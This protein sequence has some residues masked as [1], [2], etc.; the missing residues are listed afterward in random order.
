MTAQWN[1]V[2]AGYKAG[3]PNINVE[4]K[5]FE[6]YDSVLKTGLS[7]TKGPD[8]VM[9]HPYNA[10]EP[11]VQAAQ[12]RSIDP[13]SVPELAQFSEESLNSARSGGKLYGVPFAQQSLQVFYNKGLFAQAG[14]TPPKSAAEVTPMLDKLVAAGAIPFAVT[15]KDTWQLVNV[16]DA[17]VGVDYGGAAFVDAL[18]S[19]KASFTD[20]AFVDALA[21]FQ[22]LKQYFP[23]NVEGVTYTDS[24]AL[25]NS[26]KAAMFPG[27]SWEL[28]GFQQTNPGVELGVFSMPTNDGA[29]P[30]WGYEDGS[31]GIS[32]GSEHPGEALNLLR[33]MASPEFGKSFTDELKQASSVPGVQP[34][35]PLLKQMVTNYR[36]DP[37]PMIWVTDYFGVASPAPYAALMNATQNLLLGATT[38]QEAAA[39]IKQS[40]DAFT[41]KG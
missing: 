11:Y 7:G 4:F 38:P 15:G 24:Q 29:A 41:A 21:K 36:A 14:A 20:P 37:V 19:G 6:D 26:E 27:G 8:V 9:L 28:Q 31:F 2:F 35:D 1:K 18:R 32:A 30:T 25:F 17:L 12:L 3:H 10:I 16:F 22:S 39:S 40:A 5:G 13:A 34:S 33:W 23:Q